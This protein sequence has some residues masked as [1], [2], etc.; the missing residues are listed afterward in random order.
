M[1]YTYIAD[2]YRHHL[3]EKSW[4]NIPNNH[5]KIIGVECDTNQLNEYKKNIGTII[6]ML[7][8]KK[9]L[10]LND[11]VEFLMEKRKWISTIPYKNKNM[12]LIDPYWVRIYKPNPRVECSILVYNRKKDI[13]EIEIIKYNKKQ[14]FKRRLSEKLEDWKYGDILAIENFNRM[15]GPN[16]KYKAL[17]STVK[18][19]R[20]EEKRLASLLGK[21][22]NVLKS[23]NTEWNKLIMKH[24]EQKYIN[25]LINK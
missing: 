13:T 12:I 16:P 21:H 5:S 18:Q 22:N 25:E 4:D 1:E 20:I 10:M 14:F 19:Y 17:N 24:F 23:I 7:D 15:F 2:K 11:A 6:M 8:V 9:K 3:N